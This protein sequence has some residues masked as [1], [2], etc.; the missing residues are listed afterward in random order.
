MRL[1]SPSPRA[2]ASRNK[3]F[4]SPPTSRNHAHLPRLRSP[5]MPLRR[6]PRSHKPA[7]D[8]FLSPLLA[9]P[10]V[11]LIRS[12]PSPKGKRSN[13]RQ[14]TTLVQ[15]PSPTASVAPTI[16]RPLDRARNHYGIGWCSSPA[17]L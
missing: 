3:S 13:A 10:P 5:E 8:F 4:L 1:P 6:Q 16:R 15:N 17:S 11:L 14:A 2:P 7:A 12:R 9:P